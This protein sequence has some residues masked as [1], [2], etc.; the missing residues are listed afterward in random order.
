ML[1]TKP[2]WKCLGGKRKLAAE[3]IQHMPS[4]DAF[5]VYV[6]PFFGA[7]AMFFALLDAGLLEGKKLILGDADPMVPTVLKAIQTDPTAMHKQLGEYAQ[8]YNQGGELDRQAMYNQARIEW[9]TGTR[10]AA[11][12]LFLRATAYNGLWRMNRS[13]CLNSPWGKYKRFTIPTWTQFV[14]LNSALQN[15]TI[16]EGDYSTCYETLDTYD[17]TLSY[18]D[19]PYDG[20]FVAYTAAGFDLEAQ[21]NLLAQCA[22]VQ[23]GGG[24]VVYSNANTEFIADGIKE[25]WAGATIL[26][27]TGKR[28]IAA[29]GDRRG[30]APELL[31][32]GDPSERA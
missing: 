30:N 1:K 2:L 28:S 19:P 21:R 11:H 25:I 26:T 18:I 5:D 20:G 3:I 13:G 32:I 17:R 31:V 24:F 22:N 23:L 8:A 12:C 16:I 7:G 15:A 14:H 10:D 27:I 6:E 29:A 9:N 4:P